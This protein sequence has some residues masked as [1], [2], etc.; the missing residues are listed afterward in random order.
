MNRAEPSGIAALLK[1]YRLFAADRLWVALALMILGALA[2][3]FGLLMIVPLATIAI[4]GAD[5]A[6]L[7]FAPWLSSWTSDQRFIAVLALFLGA[8]G[9]RSVLLF[10]RDT[11]LARLS[12]E[13]EANLRLRA[14]ATLASR[15]WT[16]ASRIGQAGMQSLLLNDVPR[17]GEAAGFVQQLA[18]GG[19]MLAMQLTLTFILSPKLTLVALAFLAIGYLASLRLARRSVGS[20]AGISAAMEESAGSGFRLHAGLKAALAQGTIAAFLAEY[21]ST[22]GQTARQL[23]LYARD[24]SSARQWSAFGVAL[25]A[26]AMLF[27]GVR[28]LALP[29]PVLVTSLILF[30]RM[31]GPAQLVQS[32]A[33]QAA[34]YAPSFASVERRL[35]P[36]EWSQPQRDG[37]APLDWKQL[38]LDGV[39]YE[40]VAGL[41]IGKASLRIGRGDWIGLG[42][43]SGAGKTTL[44]DLV[45]GL[46]A[47]EKGTIRIDGKTLVGDAREGWRAGIAYVG[48]EGSVFSDSVRGNLLAEGAQADDV[49]MWHALETV[50]LGQRVRAFPA[51]L[52]ENVGDRGS[53]LSGGERQRLALARALLRRPSLLILD[54]ATAALDPDSEAQL[55]ERLKA[56]EPRLAALVV[57]H[58]ESTLRHC[59]SLFSIQHGVVTAAT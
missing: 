11:L 2:E 48:Q 18:V 54:E 42:G 50:G 4:N 52:N 20:G 15:G 16:F 30:A 12:A 41:G 10:A 29:F 31:S 27:V 49:D 22:L 57:A 33:L 35:G 59:D 47:P 39:A 45:A 21:D 55:I 34:A 51:G 5:S 58:R 53:Q 23:T 7:R 37:A 9:T 19:T 17:A 36:L 6:A 32:S 38:E 44:V 14:A 40:H 43:A 56:I 26:A 1:D 24:Y 3:G 46:L 25:A 28:M 13:Y 8:M